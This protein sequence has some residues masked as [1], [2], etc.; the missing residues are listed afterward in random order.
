MKNDYEA[1]THLFLTEEN[2]SDG[3]LAIL[4]WSADLLLTFRLSMLQYRYEFKHC[5]HLHWP[6]SK[7]YQYYNYYLLFLLVVCL[8]PTFPAS[9]TSSS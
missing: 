7:R 1:D 8:V 5:L 2:H 6:K 4:A 9:P 3:H